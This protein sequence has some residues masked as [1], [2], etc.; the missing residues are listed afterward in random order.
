MS[1]PNLPNHVNTNLNRTRI[2]V[3]GMKA[4]SSRIAPSGC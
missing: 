4:L 1:Y 3:V 2:G